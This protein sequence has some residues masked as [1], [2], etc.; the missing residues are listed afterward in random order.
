MTQ[1]SAEYRVNRAQSRRRAEKLQ[2]YL[3]SNVWDP[4]TKKSWS[5]FC[6]AFK[7]E[8]KGSATRRGAE[9]F[10]A[11]GDAVGPYYD[12][13]TADGTPHRVLVVPMEL[14]GKD[15]FVDVAGRTSGVHESSLLSFTSRNAHMRGVTLALQLAFG[16]PVGGSDEHLHLTTGK[17][18]HIFD[19]FAMTNLLLC[20]AVAQ[21]DS[22][23]SKH[24]ATM[25][26]SCATHLAETVNILKPTL[27]ISQGWGLVDTLRDTLGVTHE[28]VD[29]GLEKC[30]LTYCDL[31]GHRFV[32]V[33][34][35]HPTR[36]WSSP[37]QTYFKDTVTPAIKKA[38]QRA[39]K[40]ARTE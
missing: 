29:L 39:L 21:K 40:L 14:G 30:Y 4:A 34:L 23:S 31:N 25:K 22:M 15:R 36:F 7:K 18:V 13:S 1:K 38:R 27:V 6:C 37:N 16:L 20:S 2:S 10:E 28:V 11:Q 26:K 17:P 8:C 12:L 32:W 24:T 35:Y 9:F 19:S 5:S 3:T 33:A